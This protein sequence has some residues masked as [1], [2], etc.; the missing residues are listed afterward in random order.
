VI[1]T[2]SP[3]PTARQVNAKAFELSTAKRA[4]QKEAVMRQKVDARARQGGGTPGCLPGGP[5][6]CSWSRNGAGGAGGA[7]GASKFGSSF[8]GAP[9]R[10]VVGTLRVEAEAAWGGGGVKVMTITIKE[11][12]RAAALVDSFKKYRVAR[13]AV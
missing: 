2:P 8:G 11:G 9:R 3:R 13:A 1:L 5:G 4:K 10:R 6:P 12:D 7:G